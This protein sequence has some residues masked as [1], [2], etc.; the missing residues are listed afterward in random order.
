MGVKCFISRWLHDGGKDFSY[1]GIV[2][3]PSEAVR[4]NETMVRYLEDT[5]TVQLDP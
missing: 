3:D 1:L 4:L 5:P 2:Y